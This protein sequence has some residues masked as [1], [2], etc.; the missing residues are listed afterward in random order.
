[1]HTKAINKKQLKQ[2]Q[3]HN[4]N[5][6]PQCNPSDTSQSR[7]PTVRVLVQTTLSPL[8]ALPRPTDMNNRNSDS[9]LKTRSYLL[10]SPRPRPISSASSLSDE[11]HDDIR[12]PSIVLDALRSL[13]ASASVDVDTV[14][15]GLSPRVGSDVGAA[16]MPSHRVCGCSCGCGCESGCEG[17]CGCGYG[18]EFECALGYDEGGRDGVYEST[19]DVDG[20]LRPVASETSV[21]TSHI[22]VAS[23]GAA[24]ELDPVVDD[25]TIEPYALSNA[26]GDVDHAIGLCGGGGGVWESEDM[27]GVRGCSFAFWRKGSADSAETVRVEEGYEGRDVLMLLSGS[28]L[29]EGRK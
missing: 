4:P 11:C 10:G 12:T 21:D 26:E 19:A 25:A 1:M 29:M 3:Y 9:E 23:D 18:C 24:R 17:D 15:A 2:A 28:T 20:K 6:V 7:L 22:D 5:T 13:S 8:A 16:I 14:G 27:E